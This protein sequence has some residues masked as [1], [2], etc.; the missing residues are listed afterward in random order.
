MLLLVGMLVLLNGPTGTPRRGIGIFLVI[1]LAFAGLEVWRRQ[2]VAELAPA[3]IGDGAEEATAVAPPG[4]LAQ[5]A[6]L[7]ADG[8]ISDA[9]FEAASH[10]LQE[11]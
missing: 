5:L 8:T 2:A 1:V 4:R 6:A 9:E 11:P 10:R 7:H 3:Q